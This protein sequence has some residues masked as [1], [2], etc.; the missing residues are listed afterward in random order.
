MKVKLTTI[1]YRGTGPAML[2]L[3]GGQVD[4]MCDL[5]ANALPQIRG[6]KLRPIALTVAQPVKDAALAG[7]PSMRSF[8]F[9][10]VEFTIWYGLYAPRGTS[11]AIVRRL[12]A[13]LAEAAEDAGF[14]RQQADVGLSVVRDDRLSPAGHRR[15]LRKEMDRW[16][17]VIRA[18]G[19]YA[20]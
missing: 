4:L 9:E 14:Q 8:G 12:S 2:D 6:G 17:P 5:T 11:P 7:T 19:E 15:H 1:P 13:A 10:N 16:A 3:L 20:D 18:S